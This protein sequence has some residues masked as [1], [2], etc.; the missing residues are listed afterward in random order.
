VRV[1]SYDCFGRYVEALLRDSC[2]AGLYVKIAAI[3][4]CGVG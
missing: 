1:L 3:E 2:K 4:Y